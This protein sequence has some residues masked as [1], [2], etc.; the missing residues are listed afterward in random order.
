MGSGKDRSISLYQLTNSKGSLQSLPAN[1]NDEL[2]LDTIANDQ[3]AAWLYTHG[4][5]QRPMEP[6]QGSTPEESIP[7]TRCTKSMSGGLA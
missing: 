2:L 6:E 4:K 1:R 5:L 7:G 3:T